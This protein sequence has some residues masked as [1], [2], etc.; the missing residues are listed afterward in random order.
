M[1]IT[2]NQTTLCQLPVGARLIVKCKK[3]WRGAV[4]SSMTEEKVT[5][6][7]CSPGGGTYRLRRPPETSIIFDGAFSILPGC[8]EDDWRE[9]FIKYDA[10][11]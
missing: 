5:L 6:I 7:V 3:E 2:E 10:R 1:E 9:N 11:W 4:V 8:C